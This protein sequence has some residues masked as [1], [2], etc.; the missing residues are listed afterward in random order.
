M[1]AVGCVVPVGALVRVGRRG[2]LVRT[3]ALEFLRGLVT[4]GRREVRGAVHGTLPSCWTPAGRARE[5]GGGGGGRGT[6]PDQRTG[7]PDGH[8]G[9]PAVPPET[10]AK[11]PRGDG[12][13][14]PEA[15][16][17]C[18]PRQPV[19]E[20]CT[21]RSPVR[22]RGGE[23]RCTGQRALRYGP[24]SCMLP[25]TRTPQPAVRGYR[26]AG[27]GQGRSAA[28]PLGVW[29]WEDDSRT[30]PPPPGCRRASQPVVRTSTVVAL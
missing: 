16:P 9:R 30:A 12:S 7:G 1:V 24:V 2:L 27:T 17:R 15:A 25:G 8:E 14:P 18:R 4:A 13:E 5:D 22:W 23:N 21:R 6:E 10:A 26:L 3:G 19:R 20:W 11:Q 28:V 29:P